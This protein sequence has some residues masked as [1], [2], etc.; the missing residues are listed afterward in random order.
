MRFFVFRALFTRFL[1]F[2]INNFPCVAPFR[3]GVDF[4]PPPP[5]VG[6][7]FCAEKVESCTH[8]NV[9]HDGH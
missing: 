5:S 7:A 1:Y 6:A 8:E 3:S 2:V 4:L 9:Q